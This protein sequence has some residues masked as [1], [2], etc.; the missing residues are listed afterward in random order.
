[1]G[2]CYV[3]AKKR[4]QVGREK[5]G[6]KWE[7]R[8]LGLALREHKEWERKWDDENECISGRMKIGA[9]VGGCFPFRMG[10]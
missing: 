5:W 9:Q 7:D 10:G 3:G 2:N 4:A 6:R 8:K 1:M